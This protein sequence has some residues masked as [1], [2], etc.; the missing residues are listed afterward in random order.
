MSTLRR[1]QALAVLSLLPVPRFAWAQ[2]YPSRPIT[3]IMP[4]APG[5]P[6]DVIG[7]LVSQRMGSVLGQP[8]V[9]ENRAGAG[10]TVATAYVARAAPDGYTLLFATSST[11]AIAPALYRN[12]SYDPVASFAPITEVA[13]TTSL[14][15]VSG[16]LPIH[17]MQE[18]LAYAKAHPGELNYGSAG[19]GTPSHLGMAS[20]ARMAGILI[21]HVPYRS[22][23][24]AL[25]ALQQGQIQ[26]LQD[27]VFTSFRLVEAGVARAVAAASEQRL[28][29]LPDVPTLAEVGFPSH[30][31]G[32]WNG[33]MAPANTPAPVIA[34]VHDAVVE[35]LAVPEVKEVFRRFDT[36]IVGS[37]PEEF[38]AKSARE[39]ERWRSLVADLA[40]RVE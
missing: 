31:M 21:V 40:I 18:L 39:L 4:F 32:T 27:S 2:D 23:G 12:L 17:S 26:L 14:V 35:V 33:F 20:F 10:G 37:T 9:I 36:R 29:A 24:E 30:M 6:A 28:M 8:L 34:R 16:G 38:A 22:G 1:R 19:N 15:L 7:R 13:T 3:V 11:Q 25:G 5:G